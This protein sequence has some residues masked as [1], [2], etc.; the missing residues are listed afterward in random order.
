VQPIERLE[1]R[2]LLS[3]GQLDPTFGGDGIVTTGFL[4]SAREFAYSTAVVQS[5]HRII[6]VGETNIAV[7]MRPAVARYNVDGTLDT[8]FAGIGYTI[9]NSPETGAHDVALDTAGRIVLAAGNGV[10]R[11]L[12]DGQLDTTF[13]TGGIA[14]VNVPGAFVGGIVIDNAGRIWAAAGNGSDYVVARFDSA[15]NPDGSFG[16]GGTVV[17]DFGS[18]NEFAH[19]IA[20][21]G[22][23]GAI[24]VGG[25]YSGPATAWDFA[26]L[27]YDAS[28][29][30][31]TSF[32]NGG[33]VTTNIEAGGSNDQASGV[34]VAGNKIA[35]VGRG[36]AVYNLADGS[37][38]T[39][40]NG[41]GR[42]AEN[43]S[44]GVISG[45]AYDT[46]GRIVTAGDGMKVTRLNPN[47][48]VDFTLVSPVDLNTSGSAVA[49]DSNGD[50]VVAGFS[51][52]ETRS[53]DFDVWRVNPDG[54]LDG[55]FGVGGVVT[56]DILVPGSEGA[57]G[58]VAQPDGR[59]VVFSGNR[60][61]RY[62]ADG[63]LDTTFAGDGIADISLTWA[64]DL[65]VDGQ[66]RV[67]AVGTFVIPGGP[68]LF[69]FG[70]VRL[71]AD[72][73]PDVTF[74]DGGRVIGTFPDSL[75]GGFDSVEI[76]PDGKIVALGGMYDA[77][78]V[79]NLVVARFTPDGTA[80]AGFGEAGWAFAAF[81]PPSNFS[82]G[83]AAALDST[84]RI[85]GASGTGVVRFSP[86]GMLDTSFGSGGIAATTASDLTDIV[87]G[88]ADS[89][90]CVGNRYYDP[91]GWDIVVAR[92][93]SSG[94]P[95]ISFG[96][97]GA[98][99]TDFG[100]ADESAYALVYDSAAG[101]LIAGGY[102]FPDGPT[103][104]DFAAAAYHSDG[105]LDTSFGI[106]G[107][108]STDLGGNNDYIQGLA[109]DA[110]GRLVAAGSG[111]PDIDIAVV[112]Y[113]SDSAAPGVT[114]PGNDVPVEPLFTGPGDAPELSITFADVDSAGATSVSATTTAPEVPQGFEVAGTFY[115]VTTTAVLAPGS[116]A[117][118]SFDYEEAEVGDETQLRLLH[119]ENGAWV[120]VTIPDGPDADLLPDGLDIVN[121]VITGRVTSFSPFALVRKLPPPVITVSIQVKSGTTT[122]SVNLASEGVVPVT[123]FSTASFDARTIDVGSVLFAGAHANGSSFADAN[124]DGRPDLLLKFRTQDTT[125]RSTYAQLLVDDADADGVLDSTR[126][127]AEVFLTGRTTGGQ[128]FQ[129]SDD[130][131][132]FLSGK[133]LRDL[134]SDLSAH[135]LL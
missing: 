77:H 128:L 93:T 7:G 116:S 53:Y 16:S 18:N 118:L 10:V 80:D 57:G 23:G 48:S 99:I 64:A 124:S 101:R 95:D 68:P 107:Q 97:T 49:L 39:G 106:G 45:V 2:R 96:G 62:A 65:A 35:V 42:L 40:F 103:A 38:D 110:Y 56:T 74:G 33:L 100:T 127:T 92:F 79:L 50:I 51:F 31:V 76:Q 27:R 88:P 12:P 32:G 73:A 46:V 112:R 14:V 5:D 86:D 94:T 17:K 58:V 54:T 130:L 104:V 115:D 87:V 85:L 36:M 26:V 3:A 83:L 61:L 70:V 67:I 66:G 25:T 91:T 44:A 4:A 84:G 90:F 114:L 72:G 119:F 24:V 63:S 59:M 15:G 11:L 126:Q 111:G 29:A 43:Q 82:P 135:G 19:D 47:G 81:E 8:S 52:T 121:N 129:G 125:L 75:F 134:L 71:N 21:A 102:R 122:A 78:N 6:V 28:G 30:P 108:V 105:S 41:D 55:S 34:A 60:V 1:G 22:D 89:V 123:I 120:D 117:T 69:R 113:L 131:D 132:L 98:V 109:I 133:A 20:L 9:L 13:G 37:L